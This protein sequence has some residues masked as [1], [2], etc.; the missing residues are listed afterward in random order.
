MPVGAAIIGGSIISG[1]MG[2]SASRQAASMQA[3][4]AQRASE[5]QAAQLAQARAD[6]AP[7]R[8]SGET[9]NNRLMKLMGFDGSDPTAELQSTP[10]YQFRFNEGQKAVDN[11]AAARGSALSGGALKAL[12]KYGQEY[13]SNEYQNQFNRLSGMSTVGQNAAAGQGAASQAFG[14]SQA[15]NTMGAGNAMAAGTVGQANAWSNAAS[16]GINNYQQ[17]Q[18]MNL[19]NKKMTNNVPQSNLS[20]GMPSDA[21]SYQG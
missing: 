16:Q 17:N 4:A 20:W 10:G 11:S 2:A 12:T 13:G 18:L 7:W 21:S 6:L 1:A 5:Q 3:D 15:Q 14:N 8:A 19:V 9:A